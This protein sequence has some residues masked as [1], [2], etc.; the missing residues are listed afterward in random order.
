[1]ATYLN[2]VWLLKITLMVVF[3]AAAYDVEDTDGG[4]DTMLVVIGVPDISIA[5]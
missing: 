4:G 3:P 5:L 1:M 2:V